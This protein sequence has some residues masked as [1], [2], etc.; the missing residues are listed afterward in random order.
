MTEVLKTSING[1]KLSIDCWKLNQI[2]LLCIFFPGILN[3]QKSYPLHSNII[4]DKPLGEH[5]FPIVS[6][7]A[8]GGFERTHLKMSESP[9]NR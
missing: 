1:K 5:D 6:V 9:Y 7:N 3:A 8:L 2:I 4:I